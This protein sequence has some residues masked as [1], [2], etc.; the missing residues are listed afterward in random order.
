VAGIPKFSTKTCQAK[1]RIQSGDIYV[2]GVQGKPITSKFQN[3]CIQKLCNEM[4]KWQYNVLIVFTFII[5]YK[6]IYIIKINK[7]LPLYH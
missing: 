7:L 3:Y 1:M 5:C 4:L 2:G 6:M